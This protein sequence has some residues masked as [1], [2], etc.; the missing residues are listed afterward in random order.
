[1][2]IPKDKMRVNLAVKDYIEMFPD[3]YKACLDV[4][5]YQR[6]HLDDEMAEVKSTH[7]VKRMLSTV[8]EKLHEMI[9]AKI[10]NEN[11]TEFQSKETQRWFLTEYPQFR[12]SKQI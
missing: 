1:M 8:P 7:M 3:E 6:D 9:R 4:V 5:A 12:I 10:G 11:M 2:L